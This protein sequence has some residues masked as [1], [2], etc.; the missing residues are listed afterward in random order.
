MT[1]SAFSIVIWY[2]EIIYKPLYLWLK[3]CFGKF[4]TLVSLSNTVGQL[5]MA[6]CDSL[7]SHNVEIPQ[8]SKL[9]PWFLCKRFVLNY[10][11]V[12]DCALQAA[13]CNNKTKLQCLIQ[14]TDLLHLSDAFN[15]TTV[16]V[17]AHSLK[18][19]GNLTIVQPHRDFVYSKNVFSQ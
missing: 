11:S 17:L 1:T 6:L 4:I 8:R 16:N 18:P 2:G 3:N 12:H 14:K 7:T 19:G 15:G 10:S 13:H 5:Q 9:I